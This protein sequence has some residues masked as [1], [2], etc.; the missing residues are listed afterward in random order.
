MDEGPSARSNMESYRRASHSLS[1]QSLQPSIPAFVFRTSI[2]AVS[3][4]ISSQGDDAAL[5][6]NTKTVLAM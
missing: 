2:L 1:C 4:V 3:F 5:D 6:V